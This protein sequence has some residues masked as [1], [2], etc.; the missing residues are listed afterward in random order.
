[1]FKTVADLTRDGRTG[2]E[3]DR[4]AAPLIDWRNAKI[5][6]YYCPCIFI[7]GGRFRAQTHQIVKVLSLKGKKFEQILRVKELDSN[8]IIQN[9]KFSDFT[10]NTWLLWPMTAKEVAAFK[11]AAKKKGAEAIKNF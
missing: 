5:G 11:S 4:E 1:M 9:S 6:A 3:F 8:G 10:I 7:M 2:D